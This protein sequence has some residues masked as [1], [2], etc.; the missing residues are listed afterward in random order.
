MGG[1]SED[2]AELGSDI[3]RPAMMPLL[4]LH[5]LTFPPLLPF[6]FFTQS[7][8]KS[9]RPLGL[10]YATHFIFFVAISPYVLHLL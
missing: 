5:D 6:P 3:F 10:V 1:G 8:Q 9:A 2:S 7:F 4:R